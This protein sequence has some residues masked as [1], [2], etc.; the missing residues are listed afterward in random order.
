MNTVVR[1]LNGR[2]T[3]TEIKRY[4]VFVSATFWGLILLAWIGY[5]TENKYS[6][7]TH[8]F[9][10]LGSFEQKHSPE[11]WW[12]F[13]IAMVFWGTA[14][15]PLVLFIHGRFAPLSKW[16]A[17]IGAGLL[18]L[19]CINI[20]LVGVFP[21]AKTQLTPTVRV[22]DVHAKVAIL[23]AIAFILG[24]AA[25][26]LLLLRDRFA[27][28]CFGGESRFEHRP[29]VAP[30]A[31]WLAIL[32]TASYFLIKWEFVYAAKKAAA[33]ASGQSIGSSWSEAMNTIYS[34]P[35]WENLLIYTL[36]IFLVWL[37]LALIQAED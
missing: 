25:H 7:M 36:F 14:G 19:G 33:Q 16:G 26:G 21:D 10:F 11:W 29:F 2:F 31:F 9:S 35:L 24:I 34:F 22:T 23:A 17:R 15:I 37:P 30:Y 8:T 6:I 4:L 5:P 18:L 13:S 12:I 20:A 1:C 32:C 3:D 27:S 28:A